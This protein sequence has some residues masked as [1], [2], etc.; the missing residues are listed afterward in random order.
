MQSGIHILKSRISLGLS[1]VLSLFLLGGCED[2][3][4]E[5]F[6]KLE[7][8]DKWQEVAAEIRPLVE[9]Y[10]PDGDY[11]M[12]SVPFEELPKIV[13]DLKPI[14]F[15]VTTTDVMVWFQGGHAIGVAVSLSWD[16]D[17]V[18]TVELVTD[19]TDWELWKGKAGESP[20]SA[21]AEKKSAEQR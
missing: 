11:G 21:E 6:K 16:E 15:Y 18:C 4:G 13:Q 3:T 20:A 14:G 8:Y 2:R 5:L 7:D 17:D 1:I 19:G 9:K 10:K 12:K